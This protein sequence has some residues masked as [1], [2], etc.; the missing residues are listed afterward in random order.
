[1]MASG[2][3]EPIQ[4]DETDDNERGRDNKGAENSDDDD[5]FWTHDLSKYDKDG[6]IER[7]PPRDPNRTQPFKPGASS[8]PFGDGERIALS[9]R[10]RLP[11]EKGPRFAETSFIEGEPQQEETFNERFAWQEVK[12]AF[13]NADKIRLKVRSITAPRAGRGGGGAVLEVAMGGKDKWYRL[14]TLSKG[15][16]E[17]TINKS[18]QKRS[19]QGS[20]LG[21]VLR[22]KTLK[23]NK[24]LNKKKRL[25]KLS[26][27]TKRL[28]MMKMNNLL[29]VNGLVKEL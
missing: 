6:N 25:G 14:Y 17:K 18:L 26:K 28:Q 9:S 5:D 23:S 16:A 21:Q 10:T 7:D 11:K 27:R 1:M 12:D 20:T 29:Y 22:L 8:T 3:Y 24:M 15:D 4:T 2:G 13:P 19:K